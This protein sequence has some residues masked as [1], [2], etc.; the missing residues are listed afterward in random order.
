LINK[1]VEDKVAWNYGR[2]YKNRAI[3]RKIFKISPIFYG[4]L[5]CQLSMI[6]TFIDSK[7]HL[8]CMLDT[9][10]VSQTTW[11]AED[12]RDLTPFSAYRTLFYMMASKNTTK[13][14]EKLLVANKVRIMVW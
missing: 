4:G 1:T 6:M 10:F 11:A 13:Y 7:K 14:F 9:F 8:T 2:G 12:G 3:L 5:E